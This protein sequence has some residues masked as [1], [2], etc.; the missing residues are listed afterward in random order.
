M[1][2]LG[3]SPGM[4][5]AREGSGPLIIYGRRV[6]IGKLRSKSSGTS[7]GR[8]DSRSLS[9]GFGTEEQPEGSDLYTFTILTTETNAL[10]QS[11]HHRMSVIM[12]AS[13]WLDSEFTMQIHLDRVIVKK[14]YVLCRFFNLAVADGNPA[15][16]DEDANEGGLT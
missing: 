12:A 5:I 4:A 1:D 2:F 16:F 7:L 11:I 10:L 13:Q 14:L 3:I 9:P 8:I 6:V 15:I